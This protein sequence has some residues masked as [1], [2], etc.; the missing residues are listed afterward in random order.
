MHSEHIL[1]VNLMGLYNWLHVKKRGGIKDAWL[2]LLDEG[3]P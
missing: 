3:W 1:K 2:E